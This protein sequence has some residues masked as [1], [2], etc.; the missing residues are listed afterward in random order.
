ML[1]FIW[2]SFVIWFVIIPVALTVAGCVF[3]AIMSLL[4]IED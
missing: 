2:K 1:E 4:G 3:G